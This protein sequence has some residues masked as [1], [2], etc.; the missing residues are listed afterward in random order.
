M[1]H[2]NDCVWFVSIAIRSVRFGLEKPDANAF[3][4]MV[5]QTLAIDTNHERSFSLVG[6][7]EAALSLPL[8]DSS[9]FERCCS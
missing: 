7:E 5:H 9:A 6:Q 1:S 8:L 3:R 4:L 2:L